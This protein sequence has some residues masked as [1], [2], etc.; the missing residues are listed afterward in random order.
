MTV[1]AA[2]RMAGRRPWRVPSAGLSR[3][4]ARPVVDSQHGLYPIPGRRRTAASL[5]EIGRTGL[6]GARSDGRR[7]DR[8]F[9]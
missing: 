3:N 8:F 9:V 2:A 4:S 5:L 1:P 6:R 7:E